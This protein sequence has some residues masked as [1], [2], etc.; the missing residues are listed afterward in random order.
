MRAED[1]SNEIQKGFKNC[2]PGLWRRGRH[3]STARTSKAERQNAGRTAER[4]QNART[5]AERKAE[6]EN[7]SRTQDPRTQ[8]QNASRTQGSPERKT[9]NARQPRTQDPADT[10]RKGPR[11]QD[12]ERKDPQNARAERKGAERKIE[13]AR[14]QKRS[15]TQAERNQNA[16][17]NVCSREPWQG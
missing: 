4:K 7:A 11:T 6:R 2:T 14:T 1:P 3:C 10:E 8:G 9:Q 5:Q 13:N 17:Q 16:T 15:R 12:L